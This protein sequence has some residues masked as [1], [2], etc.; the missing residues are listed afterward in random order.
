MS[1]DIS[2]RNFL[3]AA[4]SAGLLPLVLSKNAKAQTKIKD[5]CVFCGFAAGKGKFFKVWEDK[6]FLAFLDYKPIN[7]GHTLL[8]PKEHVEYIFDLNKNSYEKIFERARALA[9]PLKSAT[10]AKRIGVIVE[11]F[12][13]AHAHVH[14]IPLHKGG[15]LLKKGATGVTDDEFSQTAEKIAAAIKRGK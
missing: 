5:D 7:P 14:L 1:D 4:G 10:E 6:H 11:G 8:V 3:A 15:E 9:A 12:G 13:V 2:R